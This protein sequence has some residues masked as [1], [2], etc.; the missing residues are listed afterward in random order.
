VFLPTYA[1]DL[2][3]WRFSWCWSLCVEEWF[4]LLLPV[5]VLRMRA[6]RPGMTPENVLRMIA[7]GA[8]LLSVI[9]RFHMFV[10][11][12][13]GAVDAGTAW[14]TVYWVTHY[15]LDGLAAGIFVATLRKPGSA[16][17]ALA[18]AMGAVG[19]LLTQV[20]IDSAGSPAYEF[21]KFLISALAFGVLVYVSVGDNH[22][23]RTRILGARFIADLSYSLYLV[24]PVLLKAVELLASAHPRA[25]QLV[26]VP[27]TLAAA[28]LLRHSVELTFIRLRDRIPREPDRLAGAS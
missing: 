24:H 22:W 10:L 9:A 5:V 17:W 3:G 15:R 6:L 23:A 28:L 16:G 18:L 11:Q 12:R 21:Q 7:V 27:L 26:L 1:T 13:S 14:W 4:Y 8:V 20:W 2:V 19:V 25:G